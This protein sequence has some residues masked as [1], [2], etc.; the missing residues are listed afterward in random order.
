MCVGLHHRARLVTWQLAACVDEGG[1]EIGV[2]RAYACVPLRIW[3]FKCLV[4]TRIRA[5]CLHR[6]G[7][8][9]CASPCGPSFSLGNDKKRTNSWKG[10]RGRERRFAHSRRASFLFV[11]LQSFQLS[12]FPDKP[13]QA[14]P[15]AKCTAPLPA[16]IYGSLALLRP[17]YLRVAVM[18]SDFVALCNCDL[19]PRLQGRRLSLA[20]EQAWVDYPRCTLRFRMGRVDSDNKPA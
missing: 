10:G 16:D 8:Q 15:Q 11:L 17:E 18:R 13:D 3:P 20:K 6:P 9:P 5:M 19:V 1:G 12:E 14:A 7:K 4:H 2:G